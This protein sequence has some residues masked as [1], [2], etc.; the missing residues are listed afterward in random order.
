MSHIFTSQIIKGKQ[1]GRSLGFPTANMAVD[2]NLQLENGVYAVK[3]ELNNVSYFGVANLGFKPTIEG[4]F[5]RTLEVNIF[6]FSE[7]IYGQ[8]LQVEFLKK[9]RNQQ[10]FSSL[11]KLKQNIEQDILKTKEYIKCL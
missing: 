11:D 4:D 5:P 9:I 1:L 2:D 8:R 7:D 6:D 10:K 3:I